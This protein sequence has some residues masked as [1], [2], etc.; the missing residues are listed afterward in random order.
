MSD[1]KKKKKNGKWIIKLLVSFLIVMGIL[2]FFS[3]TIM[4]MTL[5]Q[6]STQQIYG[7]TLSSITRASGTVHATVEKEVK[8]PGSITVDKI[9]SYM[10]QDVDAGD[11]LATLEI[12]EK[13]ED[14]ETARKDLEDLEKKMEYTRRTPSPDS[15]FYEQEMAVEDARKALDEANNTLEQAKNKDAL[16]N[17]TKSDIDTIR[18]QISTA[19]GEKENLEG[20]KEDAAAKRDD[21]YAALPPLRDAQ[22]AAQAEYDAC[23]K[24]PNDPEFDPEYLAYCEQQLNDAIQAVTNMENEDNNASNAVIEYNRQISDKE[25]YI[26]NLES[27]KTDKETLLEKYKELPKVEDAQRK[28]QDANHAL[29]AA[30]KTLSDA[31]TNAGIKQDQDQDSYD[32]DMQKKEKLE[33]QIQE[34]EEFYAMTEITAPISGCIIG[35][36]VSRG[37]KCEKDAVM[38]RIADMSSGFYAE[39]SVAKKDAESMAIGS[40]VKADYCEHAYVESVRP[41]PND[42]MNSCIVR[43]SVEGKYI[44]PG[45]MTLTF[46]IATSNRSYEN[47]VPLGAVQQDI[48][49]D[50]IYVLVTKSSPLGERYIARKVSVKVIAKDATSCAIEAAGISYAYCIVRTEKPIKNG[51]QVRLAQ[52]ETI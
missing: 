20:K 7:S 3:N 15:D 39:C 36:D 46:T 43:I 12:P 52:G 18:S 42:P 41:D 37:Q 34:L 33:K 27:Q 45:A 22:A 40:E 32:E 2:T 25:N 29:S 47:V 48:D 50:F 26:S 19:T 51:Q 21:A 31:R 8:A 44:Q 10:Y 35:I 28:V 17:Q 13:Q 24:D 38:F 16:V 6:V 49:G 4:N 1:E 30:Q 5:T 23:I 14:L 11:L 9:Q